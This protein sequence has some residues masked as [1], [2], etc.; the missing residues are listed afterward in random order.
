MKKIQK[1]MLFFLSLPLVLVSFGCGQSVKL[2]TLVQNIEDRNGVYPVRI[3]HVEHDYG[4]T[5]V[6][7]QSAAGSDS[8]KTSAGTLPLGAY[9]MDNEDEY[10]Y[11]DYDVE[12]DIVNFWFDID[13]GPDRIVVYPEAFADDVLKHKTFDGKTKEAINFFIPEQFAIDINTLL[14]ENKIQARVIGRSMEHTAVSITN[15]YFTIIPVRIGIGT[16]FDSLSEDTQNMVTTRDV[17]FVSEPH[18]SYTLIIP[19]ACMDSD[20]DAPERQDT[21]TVKSSAY[22][23]VHKELAM[24]IKLLRQN[25]ISGDLIQQAVWVLTDADVDEIVSNLDE[26]FGSN[27]WENRIL[28]FLDRLLDTDFAEHYDSAELNTTKRIIRQVHKPKGSRILQ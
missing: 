11:R 2:G 16:W 12:G 20:K 19:T 24:L 3:A 5:N 23:P 4:W 15:N 1:V 7:I 26:Y 21:F 13:I 8:F 9:I 28:G 18:K 22:S 14:R 17:C 27:K 10:R 6:G 25:N